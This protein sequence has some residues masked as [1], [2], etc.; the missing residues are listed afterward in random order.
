MR[1]SFY[2]IVP[3]VAAVIV[4]LPTYRGR[5]EERRGVAYWSDGNASRNRR[6]LVRHQK[7]GAFPEEQLPPGLWRNNPRPIGLAADARRLALGTRDQV[8]TFRNA[9]DIALQ[10][11]PIGQ[12]NACYLPRTS[13]VTGDIAI[14]ESV[15]P[16]A[17]AAATVV[18]SAG[19]SPCKG[20]ELS[21]RG[22]LAMWR[23]LNGW[24]WEETHL[25]RF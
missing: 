25:G 18:A 8:W 9:P 17:V 12:H 20:R 10:I 2:A 4:E 1:E 15:K 14:H 6:R 3:G 7:V 23:C 22:D 11:E 5:V 24:M 21:Q 19:S 13:H 16:E